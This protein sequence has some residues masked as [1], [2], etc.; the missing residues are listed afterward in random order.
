MPWGRQGK[1]CCNDS[2]IAGD[3][4]GNGVKKA[5]IILKSAFFATSNLTTSAHRGVGASR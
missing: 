1:F 4:G 3:E 5:K 2:Q